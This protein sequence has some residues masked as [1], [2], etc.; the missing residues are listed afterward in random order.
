MAWVQLARYLA[1]SFLWLF[2]LY[3]SQDLIIKKAKIKT[4]LLQNTIYG[5]EVNGLFVSYIAKDKHMVG[6]KKLV[7]WEQFS[8]QLFPSQPL[9]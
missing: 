3:L 6:G 2:P 8:P 5:S 1:N 7:S 9:P 4:E